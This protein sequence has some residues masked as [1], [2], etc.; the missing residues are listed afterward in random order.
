MMAYALTGQVG[1]IIRLHVGVTVETG[2]IG[3]ITCNSMAVRRSLAFTVTRMLYNACTVSPIIIS[4]NTSI[5]SNQI[6][7]FCLY[8]ESNRIEMKNLA[9]Y[10][11]Y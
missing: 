5:E 10:H 3:L 2:D 6:A 1:G 7:I 9:S 8:I 4:V 11:H